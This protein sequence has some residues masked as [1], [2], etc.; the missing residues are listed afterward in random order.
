MKRL[1]LFL[2]FALPVWLGAQTL[3]YSQTLWITSASGTVTCPTGKVWKIENVLYTS[4]I[5]DP[6]CSSSTSCSSISAH[7]DVIAVNGTNTNVRTARSRG[8]SYGLAFWLWEKQWPLWLPTG[9]S[10]ATG[11]GVLGISVVEFSET[12]Y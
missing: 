12:P 8:S 3:T 4:T 5:P 11:T 7:N 6:A 9:S 1:I 2:L 10:L